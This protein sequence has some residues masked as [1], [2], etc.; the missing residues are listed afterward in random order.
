MQ[1]R[2]PRCMKAGIKMDVTRQGGLPIVYH[3]VHDRRGDT[4][5]NRTTY[6]KISKE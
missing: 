4:R 1:T 2:F 6:A 3:V 5:I